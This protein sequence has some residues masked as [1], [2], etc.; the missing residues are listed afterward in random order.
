MTGTKVRMFCLWCHHSGGKVGSLLHGFFGGFL[1]DFSSPLFGVVV[2][3]LICGIPFSI[4]Q[5]GSVSWW[6]W[7]KESVIAF[8]SCQLL[9]MS[10]MLDCKSVSIICGDINLNGEV[11]EERLLLDLK[12]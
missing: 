10:S 4:K 3:L 5:C 2:S 11:Y 12:L 7:R 6:N 8:K 9:M 1:S